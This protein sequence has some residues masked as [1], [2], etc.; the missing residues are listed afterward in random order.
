MCLPK[1]LWLD[2][3]TFRYTA[4]SRV[5]CA[6]KGSH[7]TERLTDPWWHRSTHL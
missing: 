1:D 2:I 7:P 4:I 3:L 6:A 5:I